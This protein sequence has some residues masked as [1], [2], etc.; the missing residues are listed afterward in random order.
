MGPPLLVVAY[1][2]LQIRNRVRP[3]CSAGTRQSRPGTVPGEDGAGPQTKVTSRQMAPCHSIRP[4]TAGQPLIVGCSEHL[5]QVDGQM[6][7]LGHVIVSTYPTICNSNPSSPVALFR[8]RPA[9]RM[10]VETYYLYAPPHPR[11]LPGT[12]GFYL[13]CNPVVVERSSHRGF[14]PSRSPRY[15]GS[16]ALPPRSNFYGIERLELQTYPY[17]FNIEEAF[18]LFSEACGFQYHNLTGISPQ[19]WLGIPGMYISC[20]PR[21]QYWNREF[22]LCWNYWNHTVVGSHSL[23]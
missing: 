10:T 11:I 16:V 14:G 13:V 8:C 23:G 15:L 6:D 12:N 19:W 20:S 4:P 17:S 21:G 1:A 5:R 3:E 9:R 22:W 2:A 18:F 7:S